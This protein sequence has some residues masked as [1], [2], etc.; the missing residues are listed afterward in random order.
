MSRRRGWSFPEAGVKR[1]LTIFYTVAVAAVLVLGAGAFVASRNVARGQALDEALR[2]TE[3]LSALIVTPLLRPALAGDSEQMTELRRTI[4]NRMSDGYLTE[5]TIWAIDGTVIFSD[6]PSVENTRVDPPDEVIAA[7]ERNATHA[8]YEADPEVVTADIAADNPGFVEVYVPMALTTDR[9]LAFEAYYDY[10]RVNSL[11]NRL[12]WS[13]LPLV[14]IPLLLL[15]VIQVPIAG[16]LARR[17]RAQEAERA[18]LLEQAL[19]LSEKERIRI[20]ADLHDGPIQD[21]A[22]I[23]YA[24]GAIMPS[25][26]EH[27]QSLAHTVGD[28]VH[29]AVDS[30]RRMMVDIYPPDLT[31]GE[32]AAT[33]T[34]LATPLRQRNVQVHVD[35]DDLPELDAQTITALYR[36]AR[37][38]LLNVASHSQA[39]EVFIRLEEAPAVDAPPARGRA[40]AAAPAEP[41]GSLVRLEIADN[42]V[43][44]VE[45]DLDRR[46]E[47]HLGLRLLQDRIRSMGGTMTVEAPVAGGARVTVSLP[48]RQADPVV[49]R[50]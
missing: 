15:Q 43:G 36:V 3:R 39:T 13:I 16:S 14:F 19:T 35:A 40:A 12:L 48:T 50:G 17:V 2:M 29:H 34:D 23:G 26:P 37:E 11:A 31:T 20:A 28:T 30:L 9:K 8:A 5:V 4:V 25:L 46:A 1:Q 18:R 6:D 32:L 7:I 27:H 49:P 24:L 45:G 42:G 21:L 10:G 33:I 47:G 44:F 38:A 41:G 22:G